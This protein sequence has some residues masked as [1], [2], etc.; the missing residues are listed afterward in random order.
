MSVSRDAERGA[1]TILA[2]IKSNRVVRLRAF[3]KQMGNRIATDPDMPFSLLETTHFL[4]WVILEED[5]SFPPQL[6]FESNFD[7]T[8]GAHLDELVR[9]GRNALNQIYDCC[10][11]YPPA[12]ERTIEEIT[13]YLR[14][15]AIPCAAFYRGYPGKSLAEIRRNTRAFDLIQKFLAD[16]DTSLRLETKESI[17]QELLARLEQQDALGVPTAPPRRSLLTRWLQAL[18]AKRWAYAAP[19]LLPLLL[20]ALL[21]SP[22]LLVFVIVLRA[23]ERKDSSELKTTDDMPTGLSEKENFTAQN[24]VTHIVEVKPGSFRRCLLRVVLWTIDLLARKCFIDGSL[25]GIASIHYARW[26]LIDDARRLLFFSNYDGSWERY[27]GDFID[28]ANIGLTGLW[29]N[30]AGF[31]KTRYLICGGAKDEEQFKQWGRNRQVPTQVWYSA[32]PNESV[33]NI[34]DNAAIRADLE[35]PVCGPALSRWMQKL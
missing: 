1:L 12:G 4:R 15:H 22:L 5:E 11:E 16:S 35:L 19:L 32:H 2:R 25:G 6:A 20:A 27:L 14:N 23:Y 8:L 13:K 31:P 29:S 3:L 24:Q 30:T 17:R 10:E 18:I 7:G 33:R 28:L 26:I 9:V 21:L 34:L